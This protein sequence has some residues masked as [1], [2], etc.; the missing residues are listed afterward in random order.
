LQ[1]R[2][3]LKPARLLLD[4]GPTESRRHSSWDCIREFDVKLRGPAAL[5]ALFLSVVQRKWW[6]GWRLRWERYPSSSKC[7]DSESGRDELS[8]C[9]RSTTTF[10]SL[11]RDSLLRTL[12]I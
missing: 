7:S 8:C 12:L 3:Q 6:A 5:P 4:S 10:D 1:L 2:P 9:R 11:Q